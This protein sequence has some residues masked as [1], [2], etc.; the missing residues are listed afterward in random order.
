MWWMRPYKSWSQ[1]SIHFIGFVAANETKPHFVSFFTVF[2]VRVDRTIRSNQDTGASGLQINTRTNNQWKSFHPMLLE[3]MKGCRVF[4][5]P[6][7]RLSGLYCHHNKRHCYH[8]SLSYITIGL[9][10]DSDHMNNFL[11]AVRSFVLTSI[12]CFKTFPIFTFS[13]FLFYFR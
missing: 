3:D 2:C 10:V 6:S 13:L 5:Q 9:Q 1:L 7:H 11:K 4:V 12:L 8:I